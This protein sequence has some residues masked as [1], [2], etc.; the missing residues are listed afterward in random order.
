V[1]R[2]VIKQ[3]TVIRCG[4]ARLQLVS[5]NVKV[6]NVAHEPTKGKKRAHPQKPY[7]ATTTVSIEETCDP[8]C[9]F[10]RT[11]TCYAMKQHALQADLTRAAMSP[12]QTM[13]DEA[14]CILRAAAERP[15]VDRPGD[16]ALR[17]HEGGDVGGGAEGAA[18]LAGAVNEWLARG[19]GPA[20]TYTHHWRTIARQSWGPIVVFASIENPFDGP[21][22][23]A[24]GYRPALVLL[25]PEEFPDGRDMFRREGVR[26]YPCPEQA[27]DDGT[28][29][30]T[31]RAC[32][33]G[34]G[35]GIAFTEH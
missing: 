28:T 29:C 13:R 35:S 22:A 7:V 30:V 14:A 10:Y 24:R 34:K 4:G 1:N 6:A 23:E 11:G 3:G 16:R 21:L 8:A 26:Y 18:L 5:H 32:W 31:C 2:P 33:S 17:L 27:R 15:Y 20:W 25:A 9:H 12:L 19:G